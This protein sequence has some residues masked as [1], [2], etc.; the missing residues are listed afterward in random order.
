MEKLLHSSEKQKA[1]EGIHINIVLHLFSHCS[2]LFQSG[3]DFSGGTSGKESTCQY[4]RLKR[5]GFQAWIGKI[6]WS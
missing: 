4:R 3:P 1:T 6:P 5:L 2:Y